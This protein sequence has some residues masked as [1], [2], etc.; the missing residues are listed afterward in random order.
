MDDFSVFG[1]SFDLCLANLDRVLKRCEETN[2]VLNWE[3][4]H[5][6]VDEVIVL[7]HKISSKGIE[8]DRAKTKIIEK[9]PPPT[10]VK[11]VRGFLGH[12]G[13]Y[14]RFIK[15]FSFITKPLTNL[16][17]KDVPFVFDDACLSAFNRLKEALVSAPI[18]TLPYWSLP[19][20]IMCD[21][22]DHAVGAVMGQRKDKRLHVIYYASRTLADA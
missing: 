13:F 9:L 21:V 3:K 16:L 7:G 2:L 12:V 19:F 15:E 6:M 18:I 14:R 17:I 8:V 11:G 20:E 4:C 10:S 1:D 22:N 5:F